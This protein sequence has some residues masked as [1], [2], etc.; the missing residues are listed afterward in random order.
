MGIASIQNRTRRLGLDEKHQILGCLSQ[1]KR[2]LSTTE[3]FNIIY[4]L[5]FL[6]GAKPLKLVVFKCHWFDPVRGLGHT[7]SIGLVE[8]KPSTVYAGVDVFIVAKQATQVY[9]LPYPCQKRELQGWKVVYK[10]SPHGK[11][12]VP[13]DEDYNN[14][15]P[16]TY[17]GEFYQEQG[18]PGEFDI[19]FEELDGP[20]ADSRSDG[21]VVKD[22][23]DLDMLEK[24]RL[25]DGADYDAPP[26]A[27]FEGQPL[28]TRDSDDDTP[29]QVD[30]DYDD[31][32]F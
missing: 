20:V 19:L 17:E 13:I 8:V 18:L 27:P 22:P 14:I 7:P 23:R 1:E 21:E 15:E 32:C 10:V 4:E 24:L 2:E 12:P 25:D 29:Q 30:S 9:Y 11:L 6:R 28:Y 3:E 16:N 26:P 5:A 31:D